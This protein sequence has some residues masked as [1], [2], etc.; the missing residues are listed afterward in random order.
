MDENQADLAGSRDRTTHQ[1][2]LVALNKLF[3]EGYMISRAIYV[4]A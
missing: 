2:A 4:A 3:Y 1:A